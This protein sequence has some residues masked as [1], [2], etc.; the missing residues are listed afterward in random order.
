M[1]TVIH[2]ITTD[3][4]ENQGE[5]SDSY[6]VCNSNIISPCVAK[7]HGISENKIKW[8]FMAMQILLAVEELT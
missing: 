6:Q 1:A 4:G 2:A 3:S 8:L 5:V 7:L